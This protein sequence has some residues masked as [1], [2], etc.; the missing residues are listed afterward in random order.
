MGE[1]DCNEAKAFYKGKITEL[2]T[3][4]DNERFLKFLYNTILSFKKKWGI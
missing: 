1:N 4:C 2:V 3:N